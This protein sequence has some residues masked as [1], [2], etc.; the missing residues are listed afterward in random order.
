MDAREMRGLEIAKTSRITR[1]ER[2]W[3]V[4]S[5]SGHGKYLVTE[6]EHELR[7]NCPDCKF[8]RHNRCK[9]IIAV[10]Y[11]SRKEIDMNGKETVT[12]NMR[13]TYSQDWPAY[14]TAQSKE[15]TLFMQLLADLC[16]GIEQKPYTFGRPKIPLSDMVFCSAF[17]VFSLYSGRR[18]SSDMK[19]AEEYGYISKAPHYNS[20]FNYLQKPEMTTILKDLITRSSIALKSIE[21]DFAADST[22]FST[23]Q[24]ARWFDFKYGR[25][26]DTRIWLK[27]HLMCGVKTNIVTSVEVTE[28]KASDIR[29]FKNLISQ[30][31]KN[32]E[33]HE[34]SADKA[35][36]SRENL[37]LIE[38][39]GGTSY[40]PFK[41]NAR[42]RA[43][44]SILWK[45]MWHYYNLHREEFLEHYHKR[46]N[47]ETTMHM[48]KS[49]FGS[50]LRSKTRTAQINELLAKVLCHNICVVIQEMH[51][52]GL[53]PSS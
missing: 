26:Q 37:Y 25:N 22:G 10:E 33:I 27:A 18:F 43:G 32:F 53:R 17:K 7:C 45:K 47:V 38:E 52:F 15:K 29:Q 39:T 30:T 35:Y 48:I 41:I 49:K 40:I 34:V 6:N 16:S 46:S 31:A 11:V 5:Q 2:G 19:I 14:N 24:F 23:C 9:H 50:R 21:R 3:T 42:P 8:R 44:G 51:E 12:Q 13:V 4:P 1:S 36:S 28:G 20:V